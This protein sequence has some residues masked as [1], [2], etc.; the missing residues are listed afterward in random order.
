MRVKKIDPSPDQLSPNER[1][2][3]IFIQAFIAAG[4]PA[5]SIREIADF[6]EV[7]VGAAQGIVK[8]LIDWGYLAKRYNR[9]YK[10]ARNLIVKRSVM[11]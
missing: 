6:V 11:G 7:S 4:R 5:P 3:M 10:T 2:A 9:G 8:R 1:Q